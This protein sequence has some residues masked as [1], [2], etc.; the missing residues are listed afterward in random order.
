MIKDFI[1][2]TKIE[3]ILEH[4]KNPDPQRVR[5]IIAKALELKG[6]LP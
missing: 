6:L 4:A 5:E 1:D 2:D 3:T